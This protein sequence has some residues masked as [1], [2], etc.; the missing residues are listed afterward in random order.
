[1]SLQFD[2]DAK[3]LE[4]AIRLFGADILKPA[5]IDLRNDLDQ[6]AALYRG[7]SGVI[8]PSTTTATMSAAV[9][10]RTIVVA[11]TREWSPMIVDRDAILNAT[12]RIQPP[13]HDDWDWV[14]KE[15]RRRLE[16]WISSGD[17]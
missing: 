13:N 3:D 2:D 7:L 11:R 16:S 10:T 12:E 4:T 6:A 8:A 1:M 17:G 15:A 9:G 5:D 14:L